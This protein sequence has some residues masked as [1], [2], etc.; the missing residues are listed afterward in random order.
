MLA[1]VA[2]HT[3][4]NVPSRRSTATRTAAGGKGSFSLLPKPQRGCENLDTDARLDRNFELLARDELLEA[5][6]KSLSNQLVGGAII[7]LKF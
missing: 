7:P 1:I 5:H 2:V 4:E 3:A 6:C